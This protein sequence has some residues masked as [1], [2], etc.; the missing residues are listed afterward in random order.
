MLLSYPQWLC[1]IFSLALHS[2]FLGFCLS[3]TLFCVFS[4]FICS[5]LFFFFLWLLFP[6]L[7]DSINASFNPPW[8]REVGHL[9]FRLIP[10]VCPVLKWKALML[11]GTI[12]ERSQTLNIAVTGLSQP[13]MDTPHQPAHTSDPWPL[14]KVTLLPWEQ[15]FYSCSRSSNIADLELPP[16]PWHKNKTL[17][18]NNSDCGRILG[19]LA[20]DGV[21]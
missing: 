12:L 21:Q 7:S 5:H 3:L 16:R 18:L 4:H 17:L 13:D 10:P 14:R 6:L 2:P 20:V 9:L 8:Y 19:A 11:P 15:T 1:F